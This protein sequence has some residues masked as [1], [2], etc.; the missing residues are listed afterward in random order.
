MIRLRIPWAVL[1]PPVGRRL[2]RFSNRSGKANPNPLGCCHEYCPCR[3][4][5]RCHDIHVSRSHDTDVIA[6]RFCREIAGICRRESS[7]SPQGA[8]KQIDTNLTRN[9]VRIIVVD[10]EV[11]SA[12]VVVQP[13]AALSPEELVDWAKSHMADYKVPRQV[14]MVPSLPVRAPARSCADC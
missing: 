9:V 5:A 8:A 1:A 12:F 4:L 11:V 6:A 7:E 3:R 14:F 10:D 13:G 2:V